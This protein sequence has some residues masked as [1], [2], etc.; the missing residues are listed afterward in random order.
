MFIKILLISSILAASMADDLVNN[1]CRYHNQHLHSNNRCFHLLMQRDG[2]LV[3]YRAKTG[4]ALW[5][6][7][8]HNTGGE[9]ACMQGDGNFVVYAGNNPKWNSGTP[10]NG[11]AYLSLQD[12]GNLIVRSSSGRALWKTNTVTGC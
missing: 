9:R 10:G 12:D 3:L 1:S 6:A 8:T 11:G 7:N 2:N 5:N 4:K